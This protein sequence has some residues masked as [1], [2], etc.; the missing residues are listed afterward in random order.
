MLQ[1]SS[2]KFFAPELQCRHDGKFVFFS[3]AHLF[4]PL[5]ISTPIIQIECI[6][7][8]DIS[9]YVASYQLVTEKHPLIIR[10][11]DSAFID[12]FIL[13]WSFYFDCVCNTQKQTVERICRPTKISEFDSP[14][15]SAAAP[16]I[17]KLNRLISNDERH[18][19][20]DFVDRLMKLSRSEYESVIAAMRIIENSKE[21]LSMNFDAAYSMLVYGLESLSQKHDEY[22]PRWDDY[23]QE[24]R[25]RLEDVLTEI[26]PDSSDRIKDILISGKQFK[27]RKRFEQFIEQN[28]PKW[29]FQPLPNENNTTLRKSHLKRC[30][31]NLYQ[32][33]SGFVHELKPFDSALQ[34]PHR[35]S[36]DYIVRFGEPFLTFSGL[37]RMTRAVILGFV[38]H[39]RTHSEPERF[40]KWLWAS[41]SLQKAEFTPSLWI[42]DAAN[43]S[44]EKVYRWFVAYLEMLISGDVTYQGD[45]MRKIEQIFDSSKTHRSTL[46]SYYYLYHALHD[47]TTE[48]QRFL[49]QR[50]QFDFPNIP[51][52]VVALFITGEL[53]PAEDQRTSCEIL[54]S[55]DTAFEKYEASRF[56]RYGVNLPGI[57]EAGLLCAAGNLALN[58]GNQVAYNIYLT[59]ALEEI[60]SDPLHYSFV[61]AALNNNAIVNIL[62]FLKLKI[63]DSAHS[64]SSEH[65]PED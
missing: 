24:L 10:V 54:S 63:I 3:N 55:L 26:A 7:R 11:G 9:S 33:R 23:D 60:A 43:F 51:H 52:F 58:A 14:P 21:A 61:H 41:G 27:L 19:F 16:K 6:E 30:L 29:F 49:Q 8:G 5:N 45:V 34:A 32:M 50:E 28:L 35:A 64:S 2:G 38:D 13:L 18:G 36:D 47:S 44:A 22:S 17:V 20:A 15:A 65:Q 25:I 48:A 53:T 62:Q 57:V 42:N 39:P 4:E 37:L 59:R 56:H 46:F 40:E 12:Q 31:A 1:I